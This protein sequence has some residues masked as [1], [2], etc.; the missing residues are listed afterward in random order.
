MNSKITGELKSQ[1]NLDRSMHQVHLDS[2]EKL[3]LMGSGSMQI[4]AEIKYPR[5]GNKQIKQLLSALPV[6]KLTAI[7][8]YQNT[9][10]SDL[11][12]TKTVNF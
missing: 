7:M 5:Y 1:L 11:K 12:L 9:P 2:V 10:I 3:G 4:S 6:N 8:F